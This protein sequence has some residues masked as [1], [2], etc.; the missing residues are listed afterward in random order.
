MAI[1]RAVVLADLRAE[2][3]ELDGMVAGLAD[4]E[5]ARDTPAPGWTI[6]HQIA[7]L[8]WTDQKTVLATTD[9]QAFLAEVR[10]LS[11]DPDGYVDGGAEAG[12]KQPPGEV[13]ASWRASREAVQQALGAAPEHERITWYG[14]PMRPVSMAT[15]RMME[16][17][18]H[19]QDVA[20]ALKITRTPTAR[21]RHITH[22]GVLARDHAFTTHGLPAPTAAFRVELT[23]PDGDTWVWGPADAEQR[24]TGPALDL[25]LL[26]TQRRHRADLALVATGPDAD[27]WLEIAQSF[28][29]PS[30]EGRQPGQFG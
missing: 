19:G 6:A 26:T 23:A 7:H 20:D 14:P 21:L 29:G 15:A 16:T 25:C 8:A 18:A 27:R 1:D 17:W 12:A 13:L 3:E 10:G 28:A 24:V 5:W 9:P 22:F 30:G 2:S 11:G 4:S